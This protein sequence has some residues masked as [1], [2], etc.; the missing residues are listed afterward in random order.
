LLLLTSAGGKQKI[1]KTTRGP[2]NGT[3]VEFPLRKGGS[4]SF[5]AEKSDLA[6]KIT[7]G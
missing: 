4:A 7:R 3:S 2:G 1:T 5:G 6:E